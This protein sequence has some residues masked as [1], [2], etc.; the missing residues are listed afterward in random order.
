MR[1]AIAMAAAHHL[2]SADFAEPLAAPI[3]LLGLCTNEVLVDNGLPH[4]KSSTPS[5][6]H[7]SPPS[8]SINIHSIL[9]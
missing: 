7:G 2:G 4:S 6:Q 5:H 9:V 3:M 8:I 1:L